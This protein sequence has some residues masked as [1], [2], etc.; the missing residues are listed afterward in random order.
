V[1]TTAP[2][3]ETAT[4]VLLTCAAFTV[5]SMPATRWMPSVDAIPCNAMTKE[6]SRVSAAAIEAA[7]SSASKNDEYSGNTAS[8]APRCAA[9]SAYDRMIARFAE[10]SSP[11]AN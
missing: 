8:V 2:A 3:G 6:P 7:P 10:T 5:S 1:A 4:S 11:G 9:V